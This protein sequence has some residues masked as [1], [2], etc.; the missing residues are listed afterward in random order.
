[1]LSCLLNMYS[2]YIRLK[3]YVQK[4]IPDSK[5]RGANIGPTWVLL[6][7]DGPHVGP[8]NLAIRDVITFIGS[9]GM[10]L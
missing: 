6:A 1:M 4:S 5:I 3:L 9:C 8:M 2:I 7:P 10:W